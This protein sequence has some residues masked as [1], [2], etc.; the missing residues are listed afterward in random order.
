MKTLLLEPHFDDTAY[1]MAGLILSGVISADSLIVTVFSR[2]LFAPYADAS[3]IDQ[4]S[5]LRYRE[6]HFST[7]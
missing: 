5:A 6:L 7:F 1:S 4:I 3:G 2:T